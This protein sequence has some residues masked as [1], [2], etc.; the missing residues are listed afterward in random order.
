MQ[1]KSVLLG[2]DI[3]PP[4]CTHMRSKPIIDRLI[5]CT[6]HFSLCFNFVQCWDPS[7]FSVLN[8]SDYMLCCHKA[9]I[10]WLQM[11]PFPRPLIYFVLYFALIALKLVTYSFTVPR[12]YGTHVVIRLFIENYYMLTLTAYFPHAA[13]TFFFKENH[14][15]HSL[16]VYRPAV[17]VFTGPKIK[18]KKSAYVF[19]IRKM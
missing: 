5:L 10:P 3:W 15:A 17:V 18:V 4:T 13:Y 11:K 7:F 8:G 2:K 16:Q 12:C 19:A 6:A 1:I 14:K 9:L